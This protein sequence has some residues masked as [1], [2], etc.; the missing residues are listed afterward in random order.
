[1]DRHVLLTV[2]DDSS[3]LCSLRFLCGY[4]QHTHNMHVTLLYVAPNPRAGLSEAEAITN[5]ALVARR[6][7]TIRHKSIEALSRAREFLL[8]KSFPAEHIHTKMTYRQFGTAT[9]I[10]QEALAGSYDAVGL[11]RRG[12][13]R[14]E[15][16]LSESVSKQIFVTPID[17]PLWISRSTEKPAP[18]ALLCTDGSPA[19]L[20]CADHMAFMVRA[21][22]RHHITIATITQAPS[23]AT[24]YALHEAR[25]V[26][27]EGGIAAD[28]IHEVILHG[29]DVAEAILRHT[30]EVPYGVVGIGRTGKGES[31]VISLLGSV[32][33]RLFRQLH[34]ATLWICH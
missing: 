9:D 15:E 3:C 8:T 28:R 20:R 1:M 19:S 25:S 13:S 29:E 33:I 4:F 30:Q 12:I 23:P 32:S 21:E 11:G 10:I 34:W 31:H 27:L 2:S 6:E 26:L 5:F 17:I 22:P 18:H 24:H 16:L 14:L 7:E